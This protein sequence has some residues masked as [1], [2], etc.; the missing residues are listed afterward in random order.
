MIDMLKTYKLAQ[1]FFLSVWI[2]T[3][4]MK[5]DD[6]TEGFFFFRALHKVLGLC[7][8]LRNFTHGLRI[9]QMAKISHNF[10]SKPYS[11]DF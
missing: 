11:L 10:F 7:T 1:K 8:C 5:F 6:F 3:N 9:L 4:V 2:D